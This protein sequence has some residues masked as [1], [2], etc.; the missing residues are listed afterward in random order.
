MKIVVTSFRR[1]HASTATLSAPNPAA[2]HHQ[3][4]PPPE[5]RG[6]SWA[7]LG[8]SLVGSLLLSPGSWCAQGSVCALQE[9]ISPVLCKFWQALWWGY[10]PPPPRGLMPYPS[11]LYPEPVPLRQA[12]A[13]PYF[14]RR[15][16]NT[17]LSQSL[18]VSGSWSTEGLFEP[19][20]CLWWEWGLILNANSPLLPSCC[21]FFFALGCV[22]SF[23]GGIQ[24]SPVDGCSAVSCNYGVLLGEDDHPSSY[25]A[26]LPEA[27]YS[28]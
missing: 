12:T 3:P 8:Q 26:I 11:L 6:H 17:V 2:G 14:H 4:M 9:S 24:H 5:T 21:S 23:F 13:D 22:V 19:S 20:E 27:R 16:S 10:W 15:H 28:A 1:S 18:W 7:S 25:S